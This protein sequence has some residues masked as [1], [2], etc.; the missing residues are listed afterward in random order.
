M[1]INVE[2]FAV[3]NTFQ[4]AE[5][6]CVQFDMAHGNGKH[7]KILPPFMFHALLFNHVSGDCVPH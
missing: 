4:Q 3:D 5:G 6:C 2:K 7:G 1:N